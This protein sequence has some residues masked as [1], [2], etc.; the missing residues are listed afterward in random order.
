M[1]INVAQLLRDPVGTKR[2]YQAS[3]AVDVMGDG[4]GRP[5]EGKI[6]L[7]RTNRSILARGKLNTEVELT[8]SRCLGTFSFP[9]AIEFEEEYI[10]TIDVISGVH[11]TAPEEPGAFTIDEH[12]V[13]D[14]TEAMRQYTMMAL[15]MKPLCREDC[16]GLCAECGQNLNLGEC[17]CLKEIIDPRWSRLTELT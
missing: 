12:H 3:E 2:E 8:C 4:K 1:Q 10:P 7:L 16:A 15:P 5:A 6:S 17:R 11:L 14:L 9:L 13:I